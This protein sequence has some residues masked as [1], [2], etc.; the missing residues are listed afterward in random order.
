MLDKVKLLNGTEVTWEEF[1]RWSVKRQRA[2]LIKP[3]LPSKEEMSRRIKEGRKKAGLYD[4]PTAQSYRKGGFVCP[5]GHFKS[6]FEA[7]KFA[8]S[9]GVANAV[10]K[11]SALSKSDPSNYYYVLGPYAKPREGSK[12]HKKPIQ[13]PF[14]FFE[15]KKMALEKMKE[16]GMPNPYHNLKKKL[17]LDP[18]N[19]FF[20]KTS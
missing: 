15:S 2:N 1:S 11:F 13:T 7:A 3:N 8:E 4:N 17:L 20:I 14:G 19:Y 12:S 16:L 18:K 9:K 6:R 5:Y 10:K